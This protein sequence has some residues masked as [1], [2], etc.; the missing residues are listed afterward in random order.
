MMGKT[1]M[2]RRLFFGMVMW[3]SS[4]LAV[5]S[6]KPTVDAVEAPA[7]VSLAGPD[8]IGIFER[9]LQSGPVVF[10]VLLILVGLSVFS[11]AVVVGKNLYLRKL[12]RQ[13]RVFIKSFWDSR[14]LNDLN[15]KLQEYPYSPVREVFRDAYA[16]LVRG[17][18]IKDQS[19]Y[20]E[21]AI[22]AALEN[23]GRSLAKAQGSQRRK[24]ETFLPALA[25]TASVSPFIG[26]FGT[27]WGIMSAFESIASTG[28]TSLV[29]VAP[30]ISEALVATAFGLAAAIPAVV[31][32]NLANSR[33]RSLMSYMDGFGADFLN[34]VERY[35]VSDR[36][37]ASSAPS[38]Q[39]VPSP[40]I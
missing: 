18:Q 31:G 28:S 27:V 9:S 33:I 23:L 13:N 4:A 21:W 12:D 36:T 19:A 22:K 8:Q 26:L 15:S 14:S 17:S 39:P 2:F 29:A 11:W 10:M 38:G 6:G 20:P 7:V 16:E 40:R 1:S 35:L 37:K 5:A 25:I 34:I 3:F 32:Y 30:G 24:M